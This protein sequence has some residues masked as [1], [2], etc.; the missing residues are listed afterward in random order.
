ML[1]PPSSLEFTGEPDAL[2][3]GKFIPDEVL[4]SLMHTFLAAGT[5][6]ETQRHTH[7]KRAAS[8]LSDYKDHLEKV[9]NALHPSY[10]MLM[11]LMDYHL[12]TL[13]EHPNSSEEVS[14]ALVNMLPLY[15]HA[16]DE[17]GLSVDPKLVEPAMRALGG[18][19]MRTRQKEERHSLHNGISGP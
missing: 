8:H 5:R 2:F 11:D 14:A 7:L 13:E 19:A 18:H 10:R 6:D 12:K 15:V 4:S 3:G 17:R 9:D 16:V 1:A